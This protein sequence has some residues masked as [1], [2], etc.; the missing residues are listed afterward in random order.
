[1]NNAI[2]TWNSA[3]GGYRAYIGAG[4]VDLGVTLNGNINPG[5]IPSGQSFFVRLSGSGSYT[6]QLRVKESAKSTGSSATF[7]RTATVAS[8]QL[9]IRMSKP[10]HIGYQFDAMVRFRDGASDGFDQNKDLELLPGSGFELAIQTSEAGNLL[11]NTLAPVSETKIIPLWVDYKANSGQFQFSF[12]DV[13]SLNESTTAYLKDNYLGSL[14]LINPQTV[15][16][17]QANDAAS[18]NAGRFELIFNPNSITS[19]SKNLSQKNILVFPNPVIHEKFTLIYSGEIAH[20]QLEITDLP[21]KQV[22]FTFSHT[23][24]EAIEIALNSKLPPGQYLL[25]VKEK[26]GIR[27]FPILVN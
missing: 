6:R 16:T 4:G 3:L 5:L 2:Y 14:T 15:Y 18:M 11:L 13:E 9:R 20:I 26:N 27:V 17:Y 23:K 22:P 1:M 7:A 25:K 19:S 21:G 8:N 12:L 24:P 10:D